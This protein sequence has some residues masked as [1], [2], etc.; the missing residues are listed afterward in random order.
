[1]LKEEYEEWITIDGN[2]PVAA[3]LQNWEFRQ[4]V[5]EQDPAINIA[6]SDGDNVLTKILERTPSQALDILK[7]GVEYRSTN[8]KKQC[9]YEQ[10]ISELLR[11][12][13]RQTTI[14]GFFN[15][16]F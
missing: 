1:M 5:C 11:F 6:D 10:Y 12:N 13:C 9:E 8:F 4:S 3:E 14:N 7:N 15:C 2:I 16:Y